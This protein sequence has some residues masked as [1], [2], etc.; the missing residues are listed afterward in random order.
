MAPGPV[1]ADGRGVPPPV[2][3]AALGA[4][5]RG[6]RDQDRDGVQAG[7]LDR[8]QVQAAAR[9]AG[10][11]PAPGETFQAG[12]VAQDARRGGTWPRPGRG[13]TPGPHPG[14]RR[15]RA[16]GRRPGARGGTRPSR[17]PARRPVIRASV[18]E[19]EASRL[20]P[21]TPVRGGLPDGVQ[22]GDRGPPVQVGPD[23][24]AGVVRPGRD[25]HRLGHRV[26][27]AGPAQRGHRG[28]VPLQ[29]G[30]AQPGGVQPQVIGLG[31]S[32]PAWPRT[33]RPGGPGRRA[34][35]GRP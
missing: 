33:P 11:G 13:G 12:P 24:A 23:A 6:R 4:R 9:R 2:A 25:R 32:A 18:S 31:P 10:P 7:R 3:A 28:E 26:D 20:A 8:G 5:Q 35:G 21:C 22:P 27:A 30:P 29:D 14:R 16:A 17:S 15:R 19:L 1:R 34:G